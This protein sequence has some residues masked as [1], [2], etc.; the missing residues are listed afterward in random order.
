MS[1]KRIVLALAVAFAAASAFAETDCITLQ[2]EIV[3]KR[4]LADGRMGRSVGQRTVR[5]R[6]RKA[7]SDEDSGEVV[8]LHL[9]KNKMF[10]IDMVM[11]NYRESNVKKIGQISKINED[12]MLEQI[13]ND[14]RM[15][16][17]VK[18]IRKL[19]DGP[20]KWE[21]IRG[22]A[23]GAG[24]TALLEEYN[25]PAKKPVIVV[26]KQEGA[27]KYICG[28]KCLK[29]VATENGQEMSSA[30]VTEELDLEP[31]LYEYLEATGI[32]SP[33]LAEKLKTIKGLPLEY[34]VSSRDGR[35]TETA[36]KAVDLRKID[37]SFFKVPKGF[38]KQQG[39]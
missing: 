1:P 4:P 3:T 36:T 30:W 21:I 23:D 20:E 26:K 14:P 12:L 9:D 34:T 29:Y 15:R 37:S 38:T 25:L 5:L 24:K 19:S 32:I 27:E 28:H 8:I 39:R 35:I 16:V 6:G 17:K 18:L 10:T 7:R 33:E 22:L 11:R 31:E 13:R 2:Q